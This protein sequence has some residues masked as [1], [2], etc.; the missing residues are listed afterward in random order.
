MGAA[1][2]SKNNAM[3]LYR[4]GHRAVRVRGRFKEDILKSRILV[5]LLFFVSRRGGGQHPPPHPQEQPHLPARLSLTS[6]TMIAATA[7]NISALITNVAMVGCHFLLYFLYH[8][9]TA[10]ASGSVFF[11]AG[12]KIIYIVTASISAAS[13]VAMPMPPP[14]A[15]RP[16]W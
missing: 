8:A 9:R 14:C 12:R 16:S 2:A 6:F 1:G 11:F 13:T 5:Y 4:S 7:A 10:L 3:P 15:A